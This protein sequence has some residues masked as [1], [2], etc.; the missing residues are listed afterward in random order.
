MKKNY[1]KRWGIAEVTYEL[2]VILR[3]SDKV[4]LLKEEVNKILQKHGV[5]LVAE[6]KWEVKKLAYYI[7]NENEGYYLFMS[8]ESPTDA[9][10]KI[11]SDFRLNNDILRY[12]F[13]KKI[14]KKTA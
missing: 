11:I 13:I 4:E 12:F 8:I 5:T 9:I 3:I 2:T 14:V 6:A 10:D 7:D 1:D